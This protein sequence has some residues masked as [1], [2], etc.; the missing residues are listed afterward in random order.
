[1][2]RV[3]HKEGHQQARVACGQHQGTAEEAQEEAAGH[4][5][6]DVYDVKARAF[7]A[8]EHIIPAEG[9]HG[10]RSEGLVSPVALEH[11]Q[12]PIICLEEP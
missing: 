1:M 5:K 11:L 8:T 6:Q 3:R 7:E 12:A 9:E 2:H 4:V 10:E